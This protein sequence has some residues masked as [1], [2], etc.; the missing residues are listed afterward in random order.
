MRLLFW[1]TI[2]FVVVAFS[3]VVQGTSIPLVAPRLGVPMRIGE[4]RGRARIVVGPGSRAAGSSLGE[5][6]LGV[7]TWVEEVVR[8]RVALRPDGNFVRYFAL[9]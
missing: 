7:R 2:V 8:D 6:P 3:V 1:G 5:L 9:T 4:P